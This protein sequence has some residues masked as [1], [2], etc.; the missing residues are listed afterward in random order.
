MSTSQEETTPE[1]IP[2]KDVPTSV[3]ADPVIP[4]LVVEGQSS[5]SSVPRSEIVPHDA[6]IADPAKKVVLDA[7]MEGQSLAIPHAP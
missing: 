1:V 6:S 2:T 3:V 7:A 5:G 4:D